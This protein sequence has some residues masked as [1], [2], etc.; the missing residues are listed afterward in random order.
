VEVVG[1]VYDVKA[2]PQ[3]REVPNQIFLLISIYQGVLGMP[4]IT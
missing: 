4:E 1:A 3:P 2:W